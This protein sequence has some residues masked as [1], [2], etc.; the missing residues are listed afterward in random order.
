MWSPDQ[1]ATEGFESPARTSIATSEDGVPAV[2]HQGARSMDACAYFAGHGLENVRALRG[3]IDAWSQ[4]V[5]PK[6]PRYDLE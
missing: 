2:D 1:D 6:L 4:E 5:D 3:G